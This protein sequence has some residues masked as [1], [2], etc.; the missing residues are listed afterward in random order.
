MNALFESGGT[1]LRGKWPVSMI[2]T[3]RFP[4]PMKTV[5]SEQNF[6]VLRRQFA[7]ER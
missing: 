1:D 6:F 2:G 7:W 5:E 4:I 3:S